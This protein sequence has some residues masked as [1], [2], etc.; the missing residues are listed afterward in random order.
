MGNSLKRTR[1]K[2]ERFDELAAS[3]EAENLQ[4]QQQADEALRAASTS[5]HHAQIEKHTIVCT[6]AIEDAAGRGI[7]RI[8]EDTE[9]HKRDIEALAT[10]KK[11]E[12]SQHQQQRQQ[13]DEAIRAA[14]TSKH[15][16]QIEKHTIVCTT[17]IEDAADR[18]IECIDEDVEAH[19]RDFDLLANMRKAELLQQ[20]QEVDE[21]F[22]T[23]LKETLRKYHLKHNS[24]LSLGPFFSS[25]DSRLK[26]FYVPPTLSEVL[27][28]RISK[29]NGPREHKTRPITSL[30]QLLTPADTT[31]QFTIITANAGVGKTS[32][33]K[34]IAV[35][36][37]ASHGHETDTIST[38]KERFDIPFESLEK[39][40]YL[41]YIPMRSIPQG[42]THSIE[43]LIFDHLENVIGYLKQDRDKLRRVFMNERCLVILDGMD[44]SSLSTLV[45]AMAKRK[46]SIII[47]CR[48]WKL[49]DME[50]PKYTHINIDDLSNS[51]QKNLFEHVNKL[52]NAYNS[53]TFE[54][55]NFLATLE[56]KK[57]QPLSSNTLVGLQLYCLWYDQR[58]D[59]ET[60]ENNKT[61]MTLGPTRSHIY[62]AILEKMFSLEMKKT[63]DFSERQ[64]NKI[65]TQRPLPKC[66][67]GRKLCKAKS[68][69]IY[70]TGKIALKMLVNS[71]IEFDEE[72]MHSL[73]DG[74]FLL[75]SGI[76]S[77]YMSHKCSIENKVYHFL[78]KTYQEMFAAIYISSLNFKSEDW[79]ALEDNFNTVFSPDIMSF[80]CVMNYEQGRRCSEIFGNIEREFYRE[81]AFYANEI[82]EYQD[83]VQLAYN[84]CVNNG[85]SEPQLTLRHVEL[86]RENA[87]SI[88]PLLQQNLSGLYSCV[89]ECS[90]GY[91]ANTSITSMEQLHTLCISSKEEGN[92]SR[93]SIPTLFPNKLTFLC[94]F[95][96]NIETDNLN[97]ASCGNIKV[98]ILLN[99]RLRHVTIAPTQLETFLVAIEDNIRENIPPMEVTF[100]HGR[101]FTNK[102][103]KLRL[104][105]VT[106][107]ETLNIQHCDQL[108]ELWLDTLTFSD[109]F[110]LDLSSFTHLSVVD[111]RNLRLRHVTIAPTQ[112]EKFWVSIKDNIRENIPPMEE[113]LSHGRQFTNTL[114]KLSIDN[115]TL[116]E[117]LNIQHCDQ[118][119]ELWL[120]TLTF[121]DD[122]HLDLSSFTH[123]S[124]V[125][126][127]NLRL[128]H[129]TIAPTQLETFWVSIKD[130]IRENIPPMEVTLSHGR[131]F[132][133]TLKK[134]SLDNVT[135]NETLNIQHCDQLQ[136]L[137]LKTI[138]FSDDFHLDLSSFTHLSVVFLLNLRLRHVTIAPTQLE[139]FLVSIKDNIRE[140]TPP[141]EVTFAHGK[142]FT[143]TLKKLRLVNVTL[144]ETLNIQ[145]CDRLQELWLKTITFS[146]D[147]HLDLS[148]FTHLSVVFLLNLRLRHVTIAPTQLEK[149]LVSIK[150]NIRENTPPMEVTFAH[151]KQFTNTL[152]KLSLDN[153]TLNETL[154]I[155]HCDQLQ[156]LWLDTLTFSDDFH[157][158]LSSF[159]H[160]SEVVLQNLRLRHVTIAPTQL[161]KFWVAIKD[162][163]RENIPPM[164][165]TL[166]HGRQFTNTLKKLS[167]DNVTLNETLNIQ[168]CDQLQE[169][170][171]DTLTFSDDFHLDLSS[172]THLSEVGLRNLRL[173]HVTI[174]PTQLERFWVSIKDNI[175]ENIPPMEVTFAHGRQFTNTLKKLSLDNVTLNET[176][177][178]H[179]CDQLQELWLDTFTFSD[180]FHLDLSSFTHLSEV[181]LQNLRLRHVTIAPTQ[182]EKFWVSIK[183][184][185]R[186]NIPPM[187][188]TLSH[189]RQFTNTLKKLCLDNVTLNETLNIQHCDQ[190]QELW[191]DTLTF[192][193]DFH[194]DLS[195][196]THLSEV[197]LRNLRLR[198]VTI[199]PTQL[200]KFWVSIK[201]NIREN[202]P[203]MEVTFAHGRRFT[204]TLKK[205]SLHYVTLNETL[206]IQQCDQLQKLRLDTLTFS[207]DFRLDLSSFTHLSAVVLGNLHLRHVTIDPTQLEKFWVYI[208]DNMRENTPPMEVTFAHGRRFTTTLK[209]LSLDNVTLNETL[210]IQQC[211]QLQKLWLDT[212]TFSDDF[213]LDLSSFTHLSEVDLR[214][215][216]LRHVTIAP[217]QLEK[218]VVFI[219]YNI[220][221]NIPPMEVTFAHGRQF[222]NTLKE[223]C[224]VNVT[225]NET[226]NIQQ[227]D[228]LQKLWLNTLTFSDDFHLDLSSFTHLS[229]VDLR[230]LRLRHVTIAP[231]QLEKFWV[232]FKDNI[233]E[234]IPPMEVTFAHGRQFTNTLKKLCLDNVTL[235]ETLNIQQC[236]QLQ[237][238]WLN[239]LT[240]SDDFHLDLSS[241]THLS[242]VDLRNLRLRQVTIDPTQLEKFWVAFKDN[243]RENIP[244]MEVTF[245][246]GRQFTNTLKKLSL[247]N[248]TLNETLNIQ[249]CDQLQELWLDTFTFSDDFHLDLSSFTHLSEVLLQNL[250][251]RHVTIA[252]TQLEKFWVLIT[253]NIRENTPPMEV[254]LS[255][256]RQFTNTLKELSLVNV[257]LNETLNIQQCD[258]LQKLWL[259]TLTFSDDFH[260]D[261]SSFT[262]LSEVDLRN[263]RL[264][265][266]TIA[267]TQLEKF[268]VAFKDNIRE[269]IPPMEVTF[270]HGRQFTNTLKKLC[271]DNVTL[272][273]TLNIQQCDQ[274]QELW[275]NT[276]TFSDDFHL[277]LSS[278][279]HLSE[280]DLR[281]LRLRQVT[282]DPTQ[283]EK[284][285]VAFKDN[286][287]ENIPPMEVTFAHGRQFTNTLKK[288]SLDNVT[289]NETLNI[290]QCDQLQELWLDTFTFSD[291]F[292]LD[293]SSFTHLS[294]VLLQ[295]LRLRHVT[296]APTQLEKFWVLITDNI[297]ENTPPMEVTLSHGRQ[298][299]N[300][301]KELSLVNVTLNETLNIQQCDQLQKLQ[302]DTL[303]FSDDFHLDLSSF[304]HLSEVLLQNLRLR[305]VTIAPTQLEKFWVFIT[306]NIRENTPPME[307]TLSHGRQFTNTLKK[308]SLVNVTLNETLNIQQCDQ[309]QKLQLDTLTFSD[310]FHL[311]LSPFTDL[312]LLILHNHRLQRVTIATV[313]RE[314]FWLSI[315]MIM[316]ENTPPMEETFA[317][318]KHFAHKLRELR[319]HNVTL[320]ETLHIQQYDKLQ[321]LR[322]GTLL[323]PDNSS[324]GL[325]SFTDLAVVTL[326]N[327]GLH[328]LIIV[329]DKLEKSWVLVNNNIS[330][331]IPNII[332]ALQSDEQFTNIS[333]IYRSAGFAY[334]R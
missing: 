273:E 140:N 233:R 173:R 219:K 139:K 194:L 18:G 216:R 98:I 306:D 73:L 314:N 122:F 275:L 41:L 69:L 330:K 277:D 86:N 90:E 274:L 15:H 92:A 123:L 230:N 150:D 185:I 215:L 43:K 324:I 282:I 307:V 209:I 183:D 6:T 258:Q 156:E 158:D 266:V 23:D 205:L 97:L 13:E 159:T 168:H 83:T 119:Q 68:C 31:K 300:T 245:A 39:I 200:E 189:G 120:D 20:Q 64:Q 250:R 276:L 35:L 71:K 121:S 305:H 301:L 99:L 9:A 152:K 134:L 144:N 184:N 25:D 65:S 135:L 203:P 313:P 59:D 254:T 109:D 143:N 235:N 212:L 118:L 329:P 226:L 47:T 315:K 17:A 95:D 270:A 133:N 326:Q 78:H 94:L 197:D 22:R 8:D 190:L 198:H 115:V 55:K 136:E 36:W 102:L 294:G 29:E 223:L 309:L 166:S 271:L 70:E 51:S 263:L 53:T 116:N 236:D 229:E 164:E 110:H 334:I 232:A 61:R 244:P 213:H 195:S 40:P 108:Q 67:E 193:D 106:L 262:H 332:E 327:L 214:N 231:T 124:V 85:V 2:K 290:Q 54:V 87:A 333:Q 72:T 246:H 248:V 148:S 228:Q 317:H 293:L 171:L 311:D 62:A 297:R 280:V 174:A 186:E 155:Q 247:D 33:C 206:N 74:Q 162:N 89:I 217:T 210:N 112:L 113:T 286:I 227:C 117:T 14:S 37:C 288:L 30:E 84:E 169:L 7:E 77:A 58:M 325:F 283:L 221:E 80:L 304:T 237:E 79:L 165:V 81:D 291:D 176:L 278:F 93:Q 44:E 287:R 310:N 202:I 172:F 57:L 75:D 12:I 16:A 252:P 101:R 279:T 157:L 269:N 126:L 181:V 26:D 24:F 100:A 319:L 127:R 208:K 5:K 63:K 4:H 10:R 50:L 178:I 125:D 34:F 259:N 96:L 302:L 285:W 145:H 241:F 303:T 160:L 295:N 52:L 234:N 264:R 38:F 242:E 188:V 11:A 322:L 131:Q 103:K 328:H 249:Q 224:L 91:P 207:D 220:R 163:I 251:L 137:W 46:Y 225:L 187:E 128:R 222:T 170:W 296:I 42:R 281:N 261:L 45:P 138:T 199:A 82:I 88:G 76:I 320:N 1:G 323:L 268:W 130:N 146:D 107:N 49:A 240:F 312:S 60:S 114:K 253:D 292:H 167:L 48:P 129:V 289:L 28:Q 66:F 256:G 56:A 175:R 298:F 265:H 196:F 316:Q 142:Q 154:N 19:K 147:F 149:F 255:H 321:Q 204:N 201:D 161:E 299:T 218:F 32:F 318:G 111:L 284:F 267:P 260:L 239:T 177:N 180:D 27:Q 182:L 238:L 21:A 153:V 211:D 308:L 331:L 191:L 257:T 104:D 179:Q 243:I 272:N 132:T 105:N 141:M 3:G 151:G 192:S